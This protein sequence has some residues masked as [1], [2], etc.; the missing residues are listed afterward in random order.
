MICFAALDW[1]VD[2]L[3]FSSRIASEMP[4]ESWLSVPRSPSSSMSQVSE[5]LS[6][7]P[8]WVSDGFSF[9]QMLCRSHTI[10]S[11]TESHISRAESTGVFPWPAQTAKWPRSW[12]TT[13]S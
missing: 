6:P 1:G 5:S 3:Y 2:D 9:S 8:S 13:P 4:H 12:D 11:R 7:K 10:T